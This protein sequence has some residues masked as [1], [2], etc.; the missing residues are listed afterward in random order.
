MQ[1]ENI[2]PV[3]LA[4]LVV[5]ASP[6]PATIATSLVSMQQG[7]KGG[8]LFGIGLSVGLGF[9]GIV[10][11]TGLGV[12]LQG[13]VQLLIAL[14]LFG[15]LYLLW[16]ALQSFRSSIKPDRAQVR[17]ATGERWFWK[18]LLLNLSNPKAVFAWMAAL[19]MGL[20]DGSDSALIALST[21]VCIVI[22]V[23]IYMIYALAFS[24]LR[25]M[26]GY[27]RMRRWIDAVMA[28]LFAIAGFGLIRSALTR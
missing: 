23:A 27:Q 9:W 26:A 19:S 12:L 25:I 5:T 1:L 4:F 16:L 6:G 17:F 22:G 13:S 18:G 15:G 10:A 20:G 7:R 11:A 24:L 8:F 3:A 21:A 2:L 14:K 28:S